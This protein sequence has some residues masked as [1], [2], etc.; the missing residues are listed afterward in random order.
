MVEKQWM[1][2]P[3]DDKNVSSRG[4][5]ILWQ[6]YDARRQTCK[7]PTQYS[8]SV[9]S[10]LHWNSFYIGYLLASASGNLGCSVITKH[11]AG[12]DVVGS[13]IEWRILCTTA[14]FVGDSDDA[15]GSGPPVPKKLSHSSP[16]SQLQEIQRYYSRRA[17]ARW[18]TQ[19]QATGTPW[20]YRTKCTGKSF[21]ACGIS[22]DVTRQGRIYLCAANL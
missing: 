5:Y 9:P 21:S 3:A 4:P 16:P 10:S 20:M 11:E 19:T 13:N 14:D 6:K 8:E 12:Q 22:H 1:G 17:D 18:S 7:P 15:V 2:T